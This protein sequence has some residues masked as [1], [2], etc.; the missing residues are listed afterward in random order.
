M[1]EYQRPH[2]TSYLIL[3]KDSEVLLLQRRN[4]GYKDGMYSL[5]SGHVDENE[6]FAES[7]IR[8]AKEEVGIGLKESNLEVEE[9]IHRKAEERI[10]ISV[11]FRATEWS[12]QPENMEPEKCEEIR[13]AERGDLPENTVYYVEE[14][15]LDESE[16]FFIEPGWSKWR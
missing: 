7:M 4:T 13:W 12:G 11:F 1:S 5:V 9:V 3:E 10:Y 8:E 14:V 2:L 16:G 15:L 6:R